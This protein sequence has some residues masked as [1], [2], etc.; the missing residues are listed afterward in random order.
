MLPVL[1]Y[2]T[3]L[4]LSNRSHGA[5]P[6]LALS[7]GMVGLVPQAVIDSA[8]ADI[9]LLTDNSHDWVK[10]RC[11]VIVCLLVGLNFSI[12]MFF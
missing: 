2:E 6:V 8:D 5:V 3:H 4:L 11:L 7:D 12:I 1:L 10:S 9:R